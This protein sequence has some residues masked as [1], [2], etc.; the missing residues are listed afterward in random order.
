MKQKLILAFVMVSAVCFTIM[1]FSFGKKEKMNNQLGYFDLLGNHVTDTTSM[2]GVYILRFIEN[3]T[4]KSRKII[5][6]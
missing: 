6:P 3:D 5:I 1:V 4:I 2:R